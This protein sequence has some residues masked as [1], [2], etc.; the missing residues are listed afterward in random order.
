M[1]LFANKRREE[2]GEGR[3]IVKQD[4]Q[5]KLSEQAVFPL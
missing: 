5:E 2:T 1:K 4:V 3:E